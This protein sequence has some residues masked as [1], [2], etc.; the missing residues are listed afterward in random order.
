[1]LNKTGNRR[2][3]EAHSCRHGGKTISITYFECVCVSLA[4]V[5]QHAVRL[6]RLVLSSV[7]CLAV[8]YVSHYLL[9]GTIFGW[10]G[11]LLNIK[12]VFRFSLQLLSDT[13]LILR[14]RR[15]MINVHRSSYRLFVILIRFFAADFGGKKHSNKKFS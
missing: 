3:I 4:L 11:G 1:M 9:K 12:C 6:R 7:I 13:F 2:N 15:D 5:T 8:S 14:T 10:G